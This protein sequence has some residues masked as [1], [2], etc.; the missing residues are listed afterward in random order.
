M[1]TKVI[2]VTEGF[3]YPLLKEKPVVII[4]EL[5]HDAV[6]VSSVYFTT[7]KYTYYSLLYS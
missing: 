2:V 1:N 7:Q 6:K 3:S 4:N 5:M